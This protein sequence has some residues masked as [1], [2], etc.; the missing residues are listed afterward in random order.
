MNSTPK[1]LNL[2]EALREKHRASMIQVFYDILIFKKIFVE[3]E[4]GKAPQLLQIDNVVDFE[5]V[6]NDVEASFI[7]LVEFKLSKK[8]RIQRAI[9]FDTKLY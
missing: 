8:K 7:I 2:G 5:F 1:I 4:K 6:H 3:I 9:G